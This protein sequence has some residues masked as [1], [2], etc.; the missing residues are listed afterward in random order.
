MG[1][2]DDPE[3]LNPTVHCFANC[4]FCKKL[5]ALKRD[6]DEDLILSGRE[7]PHCGAYIDE[8]RI[9]ATFVENLMLTSSISSANTIQS[10]DLAFIPFLIVGAILLVVG[11]PLW[12]RILNLI[13]YVSPL[14]LIFR[15]FHK[16]WY[17]F[18]F[19]DPE[20]IDAVQGM[21]KSFLLWLVAN[22][23]NWSL[24]LFQP[25]SIFSG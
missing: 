19:D 2:F 16:Y 15:W 20:Y 14:I 8:D 9:A 22:I 18:R 17:R 23:L 21:K 6:A 12:F 3:L 11:Y 4:H 24:L 1:V 25:T 13:L 10:L 7:C 5:I